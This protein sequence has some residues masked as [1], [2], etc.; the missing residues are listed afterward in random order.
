MEDLS[1]IDNPVEDADYKPPQI[2]LLIP[3]NQC[4]RPKLSESLPLLKSSVVTDSSD[5]GI[6]SATK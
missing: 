6:T 1:D 3:G 4:T 5:S 2:P